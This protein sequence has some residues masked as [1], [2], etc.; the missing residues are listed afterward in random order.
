MKNQKV[1]S[2]I[3]ELDNT[4]NSLMELADT[5]AIIA[6]GIRNCGD[7]IMME[8]VMMHILSSLRDI[9]AQLDEAASAL[10]LMNAGTSAECNATIMEENRP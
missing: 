7:G 5:V 6:Q 10:I 1:H 3:S 9:R 2:I 8:N 4:D